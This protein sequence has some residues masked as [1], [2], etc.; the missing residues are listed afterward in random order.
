MKMKKF[1]FTYSILIF[2]QLVGCKAEKTGLTFKVNDKIP[3]PTLPVKMKEPKPSHVYNSEDPLSPEKVVQIN[4]SSC[5]SG[6]IIKNSNVVNE[7]FKKAKKI[8]SQNA[9]LSCHNPS[10]NSFAN[11]DYSSTEEMLDKKGIINKEDILNP[12]EIDKSLILSK[13]E[14][15]GGSMPSVSKGDLTI[16]KEWIKSIEY[17]CFADKTVSVPTAPKAPVMVP[18]TA[19]KAPVMIPSTPAPSKVPKVT[20]VKPEPPKVPTPEIESLK[21][22]ESEQVL[23]LNPASCGLGWQLK[24]S[25]II[26]THYIKARSVLSKNSCLSCHNPSTKKYANLD[27]SSTQE[28]LDKKGIQD[29]NKIIN[30]LELNKSLILIKLAN[31]GGSMPLIPKNDLTILKEWIKS[32]EYECLL[33]KEIIKQEVKLIKTADATIDK[34]IITFSSSKT[35]RSTTTFKV[36]IPEKIVANITIEESG[37][38]TI[39]AESI[40]SLTNLGKEIYRTRYKTNKTFVASVKNKSLK[41]DEKVLF[42]SFDGL[43]YKLN[44]INNIDLNTGINSKGIITQTDLPKLYKNEINKIETTITTTGT[45][46]DG[47]STI[48]QKT[49]TLSKADNTFV[50]KDRTYV[51]DAHQ[52]NYTE[53]ISDFGP[54]STITNSNGI[55]SIITVTAYLKD[56]KTYLEK[57]IIKSLPDGS[58]IDGTYS[59]NTVVGS[60]TTISIIDGSNFSFTTTPLI[61]SKKSPTNSGFINNI[62]PSRICDIAALEKKINQKSVTASGRWIGSKN[63]NVRFGERY[64]VLSVLKKVFGSEVLRT[65]NSINALNN[66]FGGNYDKY[67]LVRDDLAPSKIINLSPEGYTFQANYTF[68]DHDPIG[69]LNPIRLATTIRSC[70][71][72]VKN[73]VL[74]LNAIKNTTSDETITAT[75]VPYPLNKD[76]RTAYNLFYPAD[77][78]SEDIT[79]ALI[80]VAD[81]ETSALNQWRNVFLALCVTPEWQIP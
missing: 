29:P 70:E 26:N 64:Y 47:V 74:I 63:V 62:R 69:I 20:P 14:N 27:Y 59:G 66:I 65:A 37:P 6:R 48:I 32:I 55:K 34:K 46:K 45:H 51:I 43:T 9:C 52:L 50:I 16:L 44:Q 79:N 53:V 41:L 38:K 35:N 49:K 31:Y 13:L 21:T 5:G 18:A 78:I 23:K 36:T 19:P 15:Y 4:P 28:M 24:N 40:D 25:K 17:E 60:S 8:L 77:P 76:F 22:L 2:L 73:K 54:K 68:P 12:L 81:A 33:E 80:C 7:H 67:D 58:I 57:K 3:T 61:I 75:T 1:F 11:L 42:T 56:K 39:T 71:D 30:P 10:T 72:I